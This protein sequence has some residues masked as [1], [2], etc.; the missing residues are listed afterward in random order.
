MG[1]L[2]NIIAA[3]DTSAMADEVLKRA[4]ALAREKNAQITVL[5]S[6][7][8][9]MFE[10][11]FGEVRGEEAIRQKIEEK[12][13]LLNAEAKVDYLITI[14]RGDPSDE[15]VYESDKL[16]SDLII[17]GAHGKEEIKDTFFGSTVHNVVQRSHLPVLIIKRPYTGDYKN[18]LAP[19]DL[20]ETSAKSIRFAKELFTHTDI[21]L[22]YA[23]SQVSDMAMD[24]YNLHDEKEAYRK[25]IRVIEKQDADKF[26]KKVGIDTIEVIESFYSVSEAFLKTAEQQHSDLV[27]LGAHG[28][29][30]SDTILYAST[31]S[32]L[33]RSVPSD[34]LIYVPLEK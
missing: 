34:V 9:P 26:K 24:I 1:V 25:K 20:S 10:K 15:I 31:A 21:K 5:H 18:I 2:N 14:T 3:I 28:V 16:Q 4:I 22:A 6:I 7:D 12:M 17:I 13:K 11:L 29:E 8:I 33:M 32:F 19:T 27:I 23:Y 30:V